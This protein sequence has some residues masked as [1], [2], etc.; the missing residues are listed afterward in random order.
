MGIALV[1]GETRYFSRTGDIDM[2]S[3][4]KWAPV[5]TDNLP[6]NI[7][8]EGNNHTI[9][10]FSC[11]NANYASIFGL[12]SGSV[13]NLRIDGASVSNTGQCGILAVWLGN[14]G[15][16]ADNLLSAT[17]ENVHITNATLSMAGTSNSSAGMIAAN[18]GSSTIRNC[19]ASGVISHS[20]TKDNWSYVGGIVGRCYE[21]SS[22]DRCCLNGGLKGSGANG[23]GGIWGGTGKEKE[24]YIL[25]LLNISEPTRRTPN[26]YA[27]F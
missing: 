20:C 5:N 13:R 8:F 21:S 4:S 18:A 7:D 16:S 9:S 2:S 6:K 15:N 24:V 14:N 23:V 25:S 10:G 26:S 1:E 27:V 22:I 11:S 17:V 19:S 12:I 3:I